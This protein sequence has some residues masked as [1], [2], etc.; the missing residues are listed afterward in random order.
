MKAC[1]AWMGA[2]SLALVTV[3]PAARALCDVA[4]GEDCVVGG[5]DLAA[6]WVAYQCALGDSCYEPRVD[7]DRD[8]LVGSND[9]L[10]FKKL[11]RLGAPD[12]VPPWIM[13]TRPGTDWIL[14]GAITINVWV[15]DNVGVRGVEI[16]F[17]GIDPYPIPDSLA[18]YRTTLDTRTIPN[19]EHTI[20][21]NAYDVA[22]NLTSHRVTVRIDNPAPPPAGGGVVTVDDLNGDGRLT[23][24]DLKIGLARCV[25][26]CT[27]RALARTYHDVEIV[28]PAEITNPMIIEGAGMGQTVFR[29]P[30]PWTRPVISVSYP[31]PLVTL[32]DLTVD[33]R[34]AAQI[35]SRVPN[36]PQIGIR[37]SN[38]WAAD[39]G[40]G[41]IE[42]IEARNMLNAGIGISGGSNWIVRHSKI[43]DNG[44]SSQF[45][46]PKLQ[47]IDP[48]ARLNDPTWQ[49]VG[50][51]IVTESRDNTVHDNE[52]WN[53]NKIG[54][55]A[56]GSTA[57]PS[58]FRSGFHF[59][60]NYVHHVGM[61]IG[62]NGG[63]GGLIEH[64]TVTHSSAHG[65][66]CGGPTGDVVFDNNRIRDNAFFGLWVSCWGPNITITNNEIG[67]NC[68]TMP[69]GGSGLHVDAGTQFGGG[70]GITIQGNTVDE[71]FC[72]SASHIAFRDHVQ[73]SG[74]EFTGG[75][76]LGTVFI[77]DATD[78]IMSDTHIQGENRVPASIFL[79]QNV[80]GLTV[81]SDVTM[82]GYTLDE[83][84][85][86]D[87]ASVTNVVVE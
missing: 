72:R 47:T 41:V 56:C 52:I 24:E 65:V 46:C 29:S 23:G 8:G 51:G 37:V 6:L 80:D 67:D 20:R 78:V 45:P 18:P 55:E 44:C 33:G 63:S 42:R 16:F 26:G 74:N 83:F 82:E 4:N 35:S 25:P 10:Y 87:P 28:I 7:Y 62:S 36:Q 2:C 5:A 3:A 1:L 12:V 30:V 76:D 57:L 84:W 71:P 68:Q 60:D 40:P 58:D 14:R 64:N 39:S 9:R 59:H 15:T 86:A 85:V 31:N 53:I 66:F 50:F 43:H 32:R 77:Q 79:L 22:G 54:I 49:S 21:A 61:G 19:G 11:F 17:E 69:G 48:G 13:I 81:R 38:P 34:K 73:I 75:T 70:N 27:L